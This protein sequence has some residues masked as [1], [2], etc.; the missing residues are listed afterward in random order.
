M[1]KAIKVGVRYN[2]G[3]KFFDEIAEDLTQAAEELTPAALHKKN[4]SSGVDTPRGMGKENTR[5]RQTL[6]STADI[7]IH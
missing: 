5:G 7:I 2:L 1:S 4:P 3:L 6:R